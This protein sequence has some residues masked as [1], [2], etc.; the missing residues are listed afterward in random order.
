MRVETM[1]R[2]RENARQIHGA[3]GEGT[4]LKSPLLPPARRR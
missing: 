3:R 2:P 4:D 1:M